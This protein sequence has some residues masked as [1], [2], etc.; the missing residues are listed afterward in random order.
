MKASKRI[1]KSREQILTDLKNNKD[2]QEKMKFTREVFYP[3]LARATTSIDDAIQN[4]SIINTFIMERALGFMKEK[5]MSEISL[6]DIV[7]KTDPKSK[8]MKELLTLFDDYTVFDAKTVFE[9]MK[10]EINLFVQEENKMRGLNDLRR[11]WVDELK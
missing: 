6:G 9:G 8:E 4:L 3:A 10:S 7:S 11:V 2:F 5:K 1:N